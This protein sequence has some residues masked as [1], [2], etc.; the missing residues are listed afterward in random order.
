MDGA[1]IGTPRVGMKQVRAIRPT[2]HAG[3]EKKN[4]RRSNQC[5]ERS[6][7]N[8]TT[9]AGQSE[10]QS[11]A[12]AQSALFGEALKQENLCPEGLHRPHRDDAPCTYLRPPSLSPQASK[13]VDLH[14][15][16]DIAN[17]IK[18]PTDDLNI[19]Y[20]KHMPH[21]RDPNPLAGAKPPK[22]TPTHDGGLS[23][24]AHIIM[25]PLGDPPR[26]ESP[27]QTPYQPPR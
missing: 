11:Q 19:D 20:K 6:P 18:G 9:N 25:V 7:A 14:P 13:P 2:H 12:D 8:Q 23:K 16:G 1:V 22:G 26:E 3:K 17:L 10:A 24:D 4:G 15:H 5:G 27:D 21:E